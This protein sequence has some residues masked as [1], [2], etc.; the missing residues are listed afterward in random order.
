MKPKQLTVIVV[1]ALVLGGIGLWIARQRDAAYQTTGPGLGEKVLPD[2]P[3]NDVTGLIIQDTTNT[4]HL[5]KQDGTWKLEERYGYPADYADLSDFIRKVWELKTVQSE[6]VSSAD[7]KKLQL[8]EPGEGTAEAGTLITF[9]GEGDKDVAKLLLGKQKMR[10]SETPSQFGDDG[11]PEGRWVHVVGEG[12]VV[13]LVSEPFSNIKTEPGEWINKQEFFKVE[14][15]KSVEVTH[16]EATNSWN[17]FRET[18]GGELNLADLREGEEFDTGKA[19]SIGNLLSWPSFVD[20]ASPELNAE[21]TGLDAAVVAKLDTFEGF[22]YT[23]K[24]GSKPATNDNHYLQVGVTADFPKEREAPEDETPEDKERLDKEFKETTDNLEEKLQKHK[25]HEGWTYIVS[26]WTVENILKNRTDFLKEPEE[27]AEE[28]AT[29]AASDA[30]SAPTEV[31]VPPLPPA[32][33]YK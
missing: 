33:D 15:L 23:V 13:A 28:A 26:K 16:A 14:K 18:D 31:P 27:E 2:F 24:V 11:W 22:T 3:L 20:V 6:V 17:I 8:I 25:S 10:K 12:N 19:S 29:D 1:L 5:A 9:K 21:T 30:T 32:L 4:L 7:L